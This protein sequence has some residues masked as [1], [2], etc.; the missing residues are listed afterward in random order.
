[1]DKENVLTIDF[2]T[3]SVR[4]SVIDKKGN[5]IAFEKEV[6][7]TPYFSL[8]P[9]YA[10][11]DPNYYYDCFLKA[12][13][14][15]TENNKEAIL[16]CKA[17]S[18]TC[19]R[20]TPVFLDENYKVVRPSI[21]WLDQRQARLDEKIPAWQ[22]FLFNLVGMKN[23]IIFNRKRTPANWLKEHEPENW[24]KIKYYVP[25]TSYF[26]YR[27]IGV[28][29]DSASNMIGHFPIDFKKG[30]WYKS[31]NTLKAPIFG[32]PIEMCPKIYETGEI[33][34]SI[35]P[36]A[37]LETGLPLGLNYVATGN[38]KCCEALGSGVTNSSYAHIS[39]GTASS[40][41]V[42]NK[43]YFEPERFLPSYPCAFKGWYSGEVQVYRGYWMLNWFSR[44]FAQNETLEAQIERIA[45]EE[46][47]N[48]RLSEI[49]PGS[50][51]LIVQPYWGPSLSRPLAKGAIIGFFDIHTKYHM[52]R[53]IIEGI[54]YALKEGLIGI[55]KKTK[56]KIKYITI[57][58]G[59]SKSDAICQITADIFN[60]PVLKPA[61]YETSS[62]GCAMAVYLGLG[63]FKSLE[64]A[65]NSM[66]EISQIF[67]PN[68]ENTKKYD[69]LFHTVYT[70]LY[71]S[72]KKSYKALSEYLQINN[73]DL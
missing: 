64:E 71:P 68:K 69:Y 51:G 3:Q 9:G 47:L 13:K 31:Y 36:V 45:P 59:G 17:F 48:K 15:L 20:D 62:L 73:K 42:I 11:Q 33:M 44:E 28:L 57:A 21:I 72:L 8:K 35:T 65:K 16:T 12:V 49:P 46:V 40:V 70:K 1:M 34:G 27:L 39:Y 10:E 38:D 19:F 4:V 25:L 24:K 53:A 5:F 63:D 43:K 60:L 18:M 32:I 23:T 67:Y 2:G 41:A 30:K 14:R 61:T 58:G 56:T 26:N 7:K 52:Y 55:V 37:S 50:D 66:V 6:Y 22:T 29:G 54:A